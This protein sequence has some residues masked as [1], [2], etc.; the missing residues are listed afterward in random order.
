[1]Q[2][3]I[4]I[5][6]AMIVLLLAGS[7]PAA[8]QNRY[9]VISTYPGETYAR[10]SATSFSSPLVAGT[11]SLLISAK[12]S[13]NQ[14]QSASA[15]SHAVPLTPDLNHGRLDVYQAITAWLNSSSSNS[16]SCSLFCW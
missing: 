16:G 7:K 12:L 4:T 2:R 5:R 13:L 3:R 15:L 10:A 14:K 6:V 8:A 9:Y 1:M 11:A